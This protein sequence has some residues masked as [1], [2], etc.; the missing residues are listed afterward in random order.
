MLAGD[1]GNHEALMGMMRLSLRDGAIDA[2]KGYLQKAVE[3]SADKAG[4][5]GI[6]W[7]LLH[8][9]NNDLGAARL[10]MQKVTDLQPKSLQA[11][12]LLPVR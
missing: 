6:E 5:N 2:A 9:M 11:W 4:G 7:A 1:A 8:M 12:C 3:G 10:A